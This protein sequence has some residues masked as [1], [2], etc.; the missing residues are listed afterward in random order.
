MFRVIDRHGHISNPS[1]IYEFELVKNLESVYP[2]TNVL[3]ME[4]LEKEEIS[5]SK[6][7]KKS[8][9]KYLRITPAETQISLNYNGLEGDM[10]DADSATE[11][12]PNIGFEE[13]GLIGKKFKIRLTSKQTGRQMDFNLSFKA[14]WDGNKI[15]KFNED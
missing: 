13:N 3:Y 12:M 1:H 9:R 8:F 2:I 15:V 4:D 14:S 5:K 11:L 6:T 7:P 10:S